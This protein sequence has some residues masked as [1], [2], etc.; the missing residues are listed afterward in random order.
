VSRH[1]QGPEEAT[2]IGRCLA[3][4]DPNKD[5]ASGSINRD[6]QIPSRGFIG[7]LR[8]ILHIDVDVSGLISL[9]TIGYIIVSHFGLCEFV[10]NAF[11]A[12]GSRGYI[13]SF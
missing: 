12:C 4:V 13:K 9:N 10:F 1:A 8:Q 2:R 11:S 7:Y 5:Q 6:K 3:V